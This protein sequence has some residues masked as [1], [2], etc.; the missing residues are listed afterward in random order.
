MARAHGASKR[1]ASGCMTIPPVSPGSYCEVH[2]KVVPCTIDV[3]CPSQTDDG[4][5]KK[6]CQG[7]NAFSRSFAASHCYFLQ[8]S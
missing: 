6:P 7:K 8:V 3:F 5:E 2:Y 4:M 1:L